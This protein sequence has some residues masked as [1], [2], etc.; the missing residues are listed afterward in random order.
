MTTSIFRASAMALV[1]ATTTGCVLAPSG[2]SE[3]RLRA[4][5]AGTPWEHPF[6]ERTLPE[7]PLT[8]TWQQV[9]TRAFLANGELEASYLDWRTALDRIDQAAAYPNTNVSLGYERMF[10]GGNLKGWDRTTISVGF[11]PMQNLSFP[12]KVMAAGRV[13]FEEA[14]A[15]G[16]SFEM[17]KF[18]L[19]RRVL[20]AWL[21]LVLAA[22]RVRLQREQ[23]ALLTIVADTAG[24]NVAAGSAQGEILDAELA[25]AQGEDALRRLEAEVPQ[26]RATL[27]GLLARSGDAPL[28]PPATLP[29]PRSLPTSDAQL[30]ALAV[31]RSPE[32]AALAHEVAGRDDAL[33]FA[34]Q[35]WIPDI[36]PFAGFEGSMSQVAGLMASLPA[37]VPMIQ[38]AIREARHMLQRA[39]ATARQTRHERA[40]SFVATL[41]ALRESERQTTFLRDRLGPIAAQAV[42]AARDRYVAGTLKMPDLVAA[43]RMVVDVQLLLAEAR[44]A[45]ETRLAELEALAGVDMETL[46]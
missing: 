27:N 25:Y 1:L 31:D 20:T 39:E 29:D 18:D 4:E 33:D 9:L 45:R 41:T 6:P 16:L 14:Q 12:T 5:R 17:A 40:A 36:N 7:L 11:D 46:S 26:R 35:Q 24:T 38:G 28:E 22:E 8:P 44:I 3:E 23:L 37:R 21:D 42:A 43:E 34:W 10:S 15:S 32:L 30:L 19:Q 2:T 13:A